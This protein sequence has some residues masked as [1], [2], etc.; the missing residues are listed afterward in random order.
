[1]HYIEVLC[2]S[3]PM[4]VFLN[5]L[6]KHHPSALLPKFPTVVAGHITTLSPEDISLS[7]FQGVCR[8][9][10]PSQPPKMLLKDCPFLVKSGSTKEGH[11]GTNFT[12]HNLADFPWTAPQQNA[13]VILTRLLT[14]NA[15]SHFL[16]ETGSSSP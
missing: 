14:E 16:P 5:M 2:F 1:M 8:K 9:D 4:N 13:K 11:C 15:L 10:F 12:K 3:L 7:C 6:L